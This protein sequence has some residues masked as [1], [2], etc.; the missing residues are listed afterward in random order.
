MEAFD[1]AKTSLLVRQTLWPVWPHASKLFGDARD[2]LAYQSH[3]IGTST[4]LSEVDLILRTWRLET[5]CQLS[6]QGALEVGM[7]G[8]DRSFT[9]S[10]AYSML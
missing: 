3:G 1:K 9:G 6:S 7:G 4:L 2:S 8:A 10:E 5:M